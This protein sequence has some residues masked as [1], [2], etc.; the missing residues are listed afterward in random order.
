M[1]LRGK[2]SQIDASQFFDKFAFEGRGG[3]RTAE[4]YKPAPKI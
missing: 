3:K 1:G 4:K 2:E